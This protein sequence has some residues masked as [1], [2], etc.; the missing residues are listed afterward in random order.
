MESHVARVRKCMV[1]SQIWDGALI[2]SVVLV[3]LFNNQLET[4]PGNGVDFLLPGLPML[5]LG[6]MKALQSQG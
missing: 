3:P 4:V 1:Y 2:E 5:G 6:T